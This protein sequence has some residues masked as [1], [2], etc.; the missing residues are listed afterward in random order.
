MSAAS[1]YLEEKIINAALRGVAFPLPSGIY[2]S[3]HTSNPGEAGGNEVTTGAW[4]QYARVKAEG[5]GSISSGWLVPS[6]GVTSNAK[7]ITF[8]SMNGGSDITVTHWALYDA[9]TNGNMLVYAPLQTSRLL[10]NGDIF[11]FDIGAITV[12]AD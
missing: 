3:L 6:N 1:N 11:V 12:T 10:K 9:A 2:V 8:P 4:P 7:Q 5:T